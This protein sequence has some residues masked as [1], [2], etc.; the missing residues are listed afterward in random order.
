MI[1][2]EEIKSSAFETIELASGNNILQKGDSCYDN[3][4]CQECM[5][6]FWLCTACVACC[7]NLLHCFNLAN[8]LA[9]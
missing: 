2:T 6:T 9:S 1:H 4:K 5:T 8:N 7:T 3:K